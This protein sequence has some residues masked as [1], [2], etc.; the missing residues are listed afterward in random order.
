MNRPKSFT[1]YNVI[2]WITKFIPLIAVYFFFDY[3]NPREDF[4]LGLNLR[5]I[6]DYLYVYVGASFATLL[7]TVFLFFRKKWALSAYYFM[8]TVE[9]HCL[10]MALPTLIYGLQLG[11]GIKFGLMFHLSAWTFVIST[12]LIFPLI[13]YSY[14]KIYK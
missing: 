12:N 8:K 3:V 11:L 5:D 7:L 6:R 2:V 10:L 1:I 14:Q 4:Y 9:V 13:Y